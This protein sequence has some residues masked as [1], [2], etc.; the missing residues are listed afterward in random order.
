MV[1]SD[2]MEI[3]YMWVCVMQPRVMKNRWNPYATKRSH[4][5]MRMA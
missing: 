2:M 1:I 4:V 3:S 5:A